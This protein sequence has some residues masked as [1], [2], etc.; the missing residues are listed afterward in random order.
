M[1]QLLFL[2][3]PTSGL[4]SY[5]AFNCVSL[6]KKVASNSRTAV[7]CTIHQPSSEV[8]FLFDQIIFLKNGRIFYQGPVDQVTSYFGKFDYVCPNNYNP[9]DYVMFINQTE[10]MEV[11]ESK[12]VFMTN[13]PATLTHE[14]EK[15]DNLSELQE[16]IIEARSTYWTQ[17]VWLLK[18]ELLNTRR[19]VA[20]IGSR[21]FITIFLNL[22]YGLIFFNAAGKNDSDPTNFNSHFGAMTMITI[23]SM[24]GSAQPVM[25]QFPFE[26]PMFL[27]EYSTGTCKTYLHLFDI[28]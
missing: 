22:L 21:F 6:L 20:A 23:S 10:S 16:G 27:R 9:S 12:G 14:L 24:F 13:A 17:F 19:D 15:I 5:S 28:L 2:D 26:R 11:L 8:F 18:R 7:L 4:D 3:E 25:L 1:F